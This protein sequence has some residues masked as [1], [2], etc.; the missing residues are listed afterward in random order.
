MGRKITRQIGVRDT[1]GA[2][3]PLH[4]MVEFIGPTASL[5]KFQHT[6]LRIL[7]ENAPVTD[8]NYL[9]LGHQALVFAANSWEGV[10]EGTRV[11]HVGSLEAKSELKLCEV[12]ELCKTDDCFPGAKPDRILSI[13]PPLTPIPAEDLLFGKED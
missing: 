11:V 5:L 6:V 10:R 2:K 12:A 3:D 9:P 1:Y 13:G 7:R 8:P 4:L